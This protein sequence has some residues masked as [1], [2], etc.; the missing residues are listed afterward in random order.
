MK[1]KCIACEILRGDRSLPGGF[2]HQTELWSI[3]PCIGPFPV[4]TLILKPIR[5]VLNFSALNDN[6]ISEFGELLQLVTKIIREL[7]DCDQTYICQWSHA[8]W[9]PVH[10]HFVVQ[11]AWNDQKREFERPGPYLQHQLFEKQIFP[12][13]EDIY[14]FVTKAKRYLRENEE[15]K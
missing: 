9:E 11:P 13:P 5:H 12:D 2:I 1:E 7:S 14:N 10:I 6:E 8:G 15:K 3:E 4:G